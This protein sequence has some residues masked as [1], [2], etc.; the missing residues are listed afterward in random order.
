MK[1]LAASLGGVVLVLAIAG[2]ATAPGAHAPWHTGWARPGMTG[3]EFEVDVR[4]CDRTANTVAAMEP[5][6]RASQA[7]AGA[8]GTGPGPLA[9][10]RQIEHER[11][12]TECMKGKG[13]TPTPK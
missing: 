1:V 2:C 13:Y 7:A 11:A 3:E 6:H 5:G 8:R 9:A 12:Y 10:Q 4:D